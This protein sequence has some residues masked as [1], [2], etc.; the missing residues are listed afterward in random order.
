METPNTGALAAGWK[1]LGADPAGIVR[2]FRSFNAGAEPFRR[3][4]EIHE[5][6]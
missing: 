5:Q 6:K 3:E 1:K 2:A 4:S